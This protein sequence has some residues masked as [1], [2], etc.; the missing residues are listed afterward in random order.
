MKI[1]I[2][3]SALVSIL[4]EHLRIKDEN[5]KLRRLVDDLCMK[6]KAAEENQIE[7]QVKKSNPKFE[8]KIGHENFDLTGAIRH[9]L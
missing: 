7:N 2:E 1:A 9:L 3:E 6:L 5:V 8:I 4:R